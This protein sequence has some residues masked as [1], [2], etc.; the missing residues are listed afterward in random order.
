M[1]LDLFRLSYVLISFFI[2]LVRLPS[3]TDMD[4]SPA[5]SEISTLSSDL[6]SNNKSEDESGDDTP[7]MWF[8]QDVG[9][10]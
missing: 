1:F 9:I 6:K 7:S 8:Q 3:Q 4:L 5:G 2:I 10:F